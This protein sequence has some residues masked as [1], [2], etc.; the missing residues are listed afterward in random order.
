MKS[1][2]QE[3]YEAWDR[4]AR[5]HVGMCPPW[6]TLPNGIKNAWNAAL[7]R[8]FEV[9]EE[10]GRLVWHCESCGHVED[11]DVDDGNYALGDSEPCVHCPNDESGVIGVA[12]VKRRDQVPEG[13]QKG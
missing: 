11:V 10:R 1:L 5:E 8:A 3:A 13:E 6:E 2:A 7:E 4:E 12:V 9:A